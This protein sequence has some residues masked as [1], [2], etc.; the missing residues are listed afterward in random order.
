[1]SLPYLIFDPDMPRYKDRVLEYTEAKSK[2]ID[3]LYGGGH[4]G[5]YLSNKSKGNY[6]LLLRIPHVLPSNA[7]S[8]IIPLKAVPDDIAAKFKSSPIKIND[9][10]K[11]FEEYHG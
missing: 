7:G 3:A 6:I 1:M 4:C 8:W 2:L 10:L 9:A 5:M 11:L